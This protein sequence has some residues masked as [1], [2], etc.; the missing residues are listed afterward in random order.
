MTSMKNTNWG[1]IEKTGSFVEGDGNAI[2]AC[3]HHQADAVE[4]DGAKAMKLIIGT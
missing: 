2:M 3:A 4:V 1:G